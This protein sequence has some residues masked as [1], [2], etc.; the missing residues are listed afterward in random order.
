[1]LFAPWCHLAGTVLNHDQHLMFSYMVVV[2]RLTNVFADGEATLD[3]HCCANIKCPHLSDWVMG[4]C[5]TF[6]GAAIDELVK[7]AMHFTLHLSSQDSTVVHNA[8][9]ALMYLDF[10]LWL[11]NAGKEPTAGSFMLKAHV[12]I[13]VIHPFYCK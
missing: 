13:S 9:Q 5:N 6:N 1:M 12:H 11:D 3:S 8:S 4:G 7:D 10:V 2:L